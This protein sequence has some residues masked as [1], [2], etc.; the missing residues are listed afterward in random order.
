MR[1]CRPR[2]TSC[3]VFS[4]SEPEREV[5]PDR[6]PDRDPEVDLEWAP[7]ARSRRSSGMYTDSLAMWPSQ[8]R[9]TTT[10]YYSYLPPASPKGAPMAHC[11][12]SLRAREGVRDPRGQLHYTRT[13]RCND[14]CAVLAEMHADDHRSLQRPGKEASCLRSSLRRITGSPDGPPSLQRGAPLRATNTRA[15]EARARRE[16]YAS[17]KDVVVTTACPD[18]RTRDAPVPGPRLPRGRSR[19][20]PLC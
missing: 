2:C 14:G 17:G 4:L 18:S 6:G 7:R 11:P 12:R 3:E 10:Q 13:R 15:C 20:R 8:G 5:D 9:S 19:A 1:D 16:W